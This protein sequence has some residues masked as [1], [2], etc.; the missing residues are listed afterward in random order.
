MVTLSGI[1]DLGRK[2]R[3]KGRR[4]SSVG[5]MENLR[6]PEDNFVEIPRRQMETQDQVRDIWAQE[7]VGICE[8]TAS[9]SL[10]RRLRRKPKG[11][12]S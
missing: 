7:E 1:K 8:L 9:G 4:V 2:K 11:M 10:R 3:Y 6:Y 5:D 12:Q